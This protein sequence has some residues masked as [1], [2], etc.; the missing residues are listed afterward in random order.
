MHTRNDLPEKTRKEV[1]QLLQERLADSIDL[2]VQAK[3][4]H[5]NVKGP[6]FIALH[7]LFD[8][9]AA[10]SVEYADLVAERIVQ[11]GGVAEGTI[12]LAAKAS[13]LPEY[14]LGIHSG[15]EHVAAL[16]HVLSFYAELS[17]KTIAQADEL[18]D[19]VTADIFTGITR[20]VD[21][22]MWFVEAHAQADH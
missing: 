14:P 17:R 22:N 12:R 15:K 5:W 9:I 11:L 2:M 7:E 16:A 13:N 1:V 18:E 20:E 8:K 10:Q 3:Q 21:K 19:A 4:A 6:D